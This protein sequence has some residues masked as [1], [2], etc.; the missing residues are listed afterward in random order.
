[1]A[2]AIP[3]YVQYLALPPS[4]ALNYIVINAVVTAAMASD[5]WYDLDGH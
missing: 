4:E 1:M 2:A 5:N 3:W